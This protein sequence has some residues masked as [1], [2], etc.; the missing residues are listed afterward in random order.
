MRLPVTTIAMLLTIAAPAAAEPGK[1]ASA[2]PATAQQR[3]AEVV[4]ASADHLQAPS[5]SSAQPTAA[6]AKR[7]IPRVTTCRCGD[8]QADSDAQEQ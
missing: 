7:P 6:P 1:S 2:R 3:P 4:L 8:P 5:P